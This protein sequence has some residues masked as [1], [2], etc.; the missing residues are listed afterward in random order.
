MTAPGRLIIAGSGIRAVGQLTMETVAWVEAADV[1]CYVLADPITE[2]WVLDHARSAEDLSRLHDAEQVR[3]HSYATMAARMVDHARRGKTVVGLF[4]GHP[5]VFTSPSHWAIELA[6]SEGIEATM[7]PGVSAEDCLFADL[8][9]DPGQGAFQAFEA[10][11]MLLS[12]REPAPDAHV[13]VWQI[14]VI[15]AQQLATGAGLSVFTDYLLGFYDAGHEVVH[16]R[17]PQTVLGKPLR[18]KVSLGQLPTVA[19]S[20][21][22]TLYIPPALSRSIDAGQVALLSDGS[23]PEVGKPP[24]SFADAATFVGSRGDATIALPSPPWHQDLPDQPSRVEA[25]L[26]A[27]ADPATLAVYEKQ[28]GVFLGAAGLDTVEL[29]AALTGNEEWLAACIRYGSGVAAAVALG[30]VDTEEQARAL[31]IAADGRLVRRRS[32]GVPKTGAT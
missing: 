12:K 28:P 20:V 7:L 29:W 26:D 10:T 1:V 30:V 6:Q 17:A 15:A 21:T 13:V 27:L 3:L 14:G 18:Q 8:G 23:A 19:A 5:G 24:S 9:V 11:E 25:L 16:Y 32:T 31:L 2:R 4:Y 22:S